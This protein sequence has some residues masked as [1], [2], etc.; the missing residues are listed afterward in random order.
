MVTMPPTTM[1]TAT[2]PIVTAKM[3]PVRLLHADM[4]LSAALMP[5]GS[6]SF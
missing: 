4:R 3:V 5:K 2:T 6:S 1:K